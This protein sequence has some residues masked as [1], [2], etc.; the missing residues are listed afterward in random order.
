MRDGLQ[1]PSPVVL[2]IEDEEEWQEFRSLVVSEVNPGGI[3]GR[4]LAERAASLMWRLRRPAVAEAGA[5]RTSLAARV[6]GY[7]AERAVRASFADDDA[8][9]ELSEREKL[10]IDRMVESLHVPS[11]RSSERIARHESHLSR[12]LYAALAELRRM[13]EERRGR[14]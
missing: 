10:E 14:R 2:E 13:R 5:I 7:W 1:S 4:E 9:D 3:V 6:W 8:T 12:E 11:Q